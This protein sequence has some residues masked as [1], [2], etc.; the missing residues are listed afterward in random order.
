MPSAPSGLTAIANNASSINLSWIDASST[1]YGFQVYRS[2]DNSSFSWVVNLTI[3]S[4]AYVDNS[5]A[6]LT[7]YYYKVGSA[8]IIGDLNYSNVASATT[9]GT[10]SAPTDSFTS[11]LAVSGS[12][13]GSLSN[14]AGYTANQQVT[15]LNATSGRKYFMASANFSGANVDF[16]SLKIETSAGKIAVNASGVTGLYGTHTLWLPKTG[17]NSVY[18]C[19]N[20]VAVSEVS[21]GCSGVITFNSIGTQSGVTL[22]IDGSY[23][24]IAG[25]TG[26]GGGE[27]GPVGV[28][29]FSTITLL[30][31]L[32]IVAGGL[33][34]IRR[35]EY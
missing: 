11:G 22:S 35:R 28:P 18:V 12:V 17:D 32:G 25:L 5:L 24:K 14:G 31:A 19:P 33:V 3:N 27:G 29:E 2:L 30:L 6:A 7:T 13:D 9:G 21:A 1:E 23:W 4:T 10:Y 34:M 8:N 16:S 15:F 20:A 26:S